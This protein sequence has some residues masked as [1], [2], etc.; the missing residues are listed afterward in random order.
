MRVQMVVLG[1]VLLSALI[2]FLIGFEREWRG[3][4]AGDRT[5]AL[6]A[7]GA[8]AFAG[9]GTEYFPASAEKVFAGIIAGVGFLGGGLI[10]RQQTGEA[11]GLTTAS[12][13]WAVAALSTMIGAGLYLVGLATGALTMLVLEI[14]FIPGLRRIE[15]M[16]ARVHQAQGG[17]GTWQVPPPPE[18]PG[19]AGS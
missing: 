7:A 17:T 19:P 8:A 4:R 3:A 16:N 11:H 5:F 14:E 10:F 2:G 15:A 9:L 18:P 12:A 6:L 13:V 1:R